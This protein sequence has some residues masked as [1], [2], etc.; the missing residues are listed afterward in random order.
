MQ[1]QCSAVFENVLGKNVRELPVR[2]LGA[3]VFRRQR[4][5]IAC[6]REKQRTYRFLG[7][8]A[9]R[10][11]AVKRLPVIYP[12]HRMPRP[13]DLLEPFVANLPD[14]AAIADAP[15]GERV[16][17]GFEYRQK[18][19]NQRWRQSRHLRHEASQG[20]EPR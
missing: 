5:D 3:K 6:G 15:P 18:V 4:R 16:L 19:Q 2:A 9:A 11:R 10:K 1:D 13:F 12:V 7:G 8:I 17:P 14:L 20:N